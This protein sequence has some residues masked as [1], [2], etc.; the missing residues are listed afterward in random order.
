MGQP[1]QP[2]G[3]LFAIGVDCQRIGQVR[4]NAVVAVLDPHDGQVARPGDEVVVGWWGSVTLCRKQCDVAV[5]GIVLDQG[6]IAQPG[7]RV[8]FSQCSLDMKEWVGNVVPPKDDFARVGIAQLVLDN[9]I[10]WT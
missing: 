1:A 6:N 8:V 3:L 10:P 5:L 2:V 7:G 4:V 9:A